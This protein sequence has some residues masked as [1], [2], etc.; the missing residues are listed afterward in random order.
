MHTL[1]SSR[2]NLRS[3]ISALKTKQLREVLRECSSS[4]RLMRT[5]GWARCRS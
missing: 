4:R 3:S 2:H 1:F 5:V